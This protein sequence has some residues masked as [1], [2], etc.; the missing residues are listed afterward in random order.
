V[1]CAC[2]WRGA[3][4]EG[5]FVF[6]ICGG[7]F[8]NWKWLLVGF[9]MV[10]STFYFPLRGFMRLLLLMYMHCL[11]SKMFERSYKSIIFYLLNI[12]LINIIF[13]IFFSFGQL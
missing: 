5:F 3:A 12:K 7:N 1:F 13:F 6:P 4:E 9:F 8:K 11:M 10:I 2:L